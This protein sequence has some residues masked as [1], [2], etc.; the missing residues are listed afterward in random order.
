M[1]SVWYSRPH[2]SRS[3]ASGKSCSAGNHLSSSQPPFAKDVPALE[4]RQPEP[5]PTLQR[6]DLQEPTSLTRGRRKLPLRM[7]APPRGR[8]QEPEMID[9]ERLED[10]LMEDPDRTPEQVLEKVSAKPKK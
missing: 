6:P 10:V 9:A 1:C 2:S 4:F 5:V 7:D 3:S 8:Q